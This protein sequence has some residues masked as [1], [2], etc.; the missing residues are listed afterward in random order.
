[1]KQAIIEPALRIKL[2]GVCNRTCSFC[3]EEG[4][5]RG[6]GAVVPNEDFFECV[7][8]LVNSLELRRVMLTGG[9]PTLHQNLLKIVRRITCPDISMTTNGIR[10]LDIQRWIA[11]REA[12]LRKVIV[13]IHD[14]MPQDLIQLETR[15]RKFGWAQQALKAQKMNLVS[16]SQAGLNVRVNTVVYSS[17]E[18][19]V[20]VL[21]ALAVFQVEHGF[22]IR[23]LNDL[24]NIELS[25]MAISHI[26]ETLQ[27]EEVGVS[28]RAGSSNSV[29]AWR[30][31]SGFEFST[32]TSYRYFFD[33]VCRS[34]PIQA[35][36]HEGFYGIRLE[37]RDDDYWVRLC[38]YKHTP[39][40]LMPWR[41]FLSSSLAQEFVELC[42]SEQ[43]LDN[44]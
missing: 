11:L 38:M 13:S 32:K 34:C 33:P 36:C 28:R 8:T 40:V 20:G 15:K 9:E 24:S 26:C 2:T 31:G 25:Q 29:T 30:A 27:A 14:V 19:T 10:Y 16:A 17:Q 37:R 23:L 41:N 4:D 35:Q 39:D 7:E 6:I 42:K 18:H 21:N 5:M 44:N 3:H 1:M 12:G 22:E 43:G